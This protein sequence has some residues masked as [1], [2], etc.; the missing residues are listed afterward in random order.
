MF[1]WVKSDRIM[2][3]GNGRGKYDFLLFGW[4]ENG[5]KIEWDG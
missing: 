2:E 4:S 5:E 1:G 3:E